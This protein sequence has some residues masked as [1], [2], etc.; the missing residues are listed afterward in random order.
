M[1]PII[2]K[3]YLYALECCPFSRKGLE[4]TIKSGPRMTVH[5]GEVFHAI[6]KENFHGNFGVRETN[7]FLIFGREQ[8]RWVC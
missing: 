6:C 1:V 7:S 3:D 2:S 4:R 8:G 5:G